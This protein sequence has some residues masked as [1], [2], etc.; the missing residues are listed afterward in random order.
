MPLLSAEKQTLIFFEFFNRI[1]RKRLSTQA[2]MNFRFKD[3]LK[4]IIDGSKPNIF[5]DLS[6]KFGWIQT[7]YKLR[8]R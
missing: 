2:R 3:F 1:G 4:N 6:I 8:Y 5:M 7:G